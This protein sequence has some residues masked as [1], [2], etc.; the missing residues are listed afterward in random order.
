LEVSQAVTIASTNDPTLRIW[1]LKLWFILWHKF[2]F[3]ES[4]G[5]WGMVVK[6]LASIGLAAGLAISL[7]TAVNAAPVLV[8]TTTNPTGINSLVVDGTIYDVT[9][10]TTTLNSFTPGSTLSLDAS[11]ALASA[12]NALSVTELG[13]FS[14]TVQYLIDVDNVLTTI[15]PAQWDGVGCL[16]ITVTTCTGTTDSFAHDWQVSSAQGTWSLGANFTNVYYVEAADFT[17]VGTAPATGVPEPFTLSF[18]GV[19]LLGVAAMRR[20]PSRREA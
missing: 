15:I 2:C 20:W 8:G 17:P 12:L 5:V 1:P 6:P 19:G 9:F 3:V 7:A 18:F 4:Q 11:S 14:P 16:T 10:S 13:N